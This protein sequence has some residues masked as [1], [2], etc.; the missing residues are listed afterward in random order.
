MEERGIDSHRGSYEK[1]N[2]LGNLRRGIDSYWDLTWMIN[3][4]ICQ[5][6]IALSTLSKHTESGFQQGI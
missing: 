5:I 1:K 2:G 3:K 6:R 4:K